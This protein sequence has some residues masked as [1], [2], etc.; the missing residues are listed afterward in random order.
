MMHPASFDT[1]DYD[2]G[3]ALIE[4]KN[5]IPLVLITMGKDGSR[6]YYRGRKVEAA[7]FLQEKTIETTGAGDTFCASTLNYVLSPPA[8][9]SQLFKA[10]KQK[11]NSIKE[12]HT[13]QI[14]RAH[15]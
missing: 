13:L 15:V 10:N 3:A 11:N 8:V 4:E 7:P 14:G 9:F 2:K 12:K 5:H 6:A 1:T